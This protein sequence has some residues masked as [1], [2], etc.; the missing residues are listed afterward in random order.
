MAALV[1]RVLG[2]PRAKG[3][4]RAFVTPRGR[5]HLVDSNRYLK[6]WAAGIAT[7]AQLALADLPPADRA[8]VVGAVRLT[9]R[10]ALPRPK[11]LARHVA[12]H[13]TKPDLDKLVRGI[14]DALTG[15]RWRD[16][17][18]VVELLAT[19]RYAARDEPPHVDVR[20]DL[21]DGTDALAVAPAPLPLVLEG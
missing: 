12:P 8:L 2:V 7:G 11:R 18:Q 14:F 20:V 15:I 1:F 5:A 13:I 19:K 3:S 17:A 16:D 4:M 21:T 10:F 9:L 6:S